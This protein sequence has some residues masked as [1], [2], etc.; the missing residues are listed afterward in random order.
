MR[1]PILANKP[2]PREVSAAM[3][4]FISYDTSR[5]PVIDSLKKAFEVV[6]GYRTAD[7]LWGRLAYNLSRPKTMRR[8]AIVESTAALDILKS[9]AD[10]DLRSMA[11]QSLQELHGDEAKHAL[12]TKIR[13]YDGVGSPRDI[14]DAIRLL[15]PGIHNNDP[16]SD[17][18]ISPLLQRVME[19]INL[20]IAF[21]D[22][23]LSVDVKEG[24]TAFEGS[25][26]YYQ[27]ARVYCKA[28]LEASDSALTAA[29]LNRNQINELAG[30]LT[31]K[32]NK[33]EELRTPA[34]VR[35]SGT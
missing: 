2:T 26:N 23:S 1:V 3:R 27:S 13:E 10:G 9:S 18:S 30:K 17:K 5:Y 12:Y 11:L 35:P 22:L 32:L 28:L 29:G 16:A 21:G 19:L 31:E 7:D 4:T 34:Q 15:P 6:N 14:S 24:R 8:Y 33:L 25:T 20:D